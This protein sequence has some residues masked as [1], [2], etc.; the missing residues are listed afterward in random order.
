MMK[1]VALD[2]DV[3]SKNNK[4]LMFVAIEV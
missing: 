2:D 3:L 4:V 1:I